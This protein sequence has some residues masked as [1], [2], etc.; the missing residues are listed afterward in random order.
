[1]SEAYRANSIGGGSHRGDG[2]SIARIAADWLG[3]AAAPTFAMMA[4]ITAALAA[5][6]AALLGIGT[7]FAHERNGPDV[8]C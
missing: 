6:R 3:L 4:L 5:A 1:M 2:A 8:L 7:R